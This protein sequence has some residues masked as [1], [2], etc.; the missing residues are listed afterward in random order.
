MDRVK[1]PAMNRI[2]AALVLASFAIVAC[3]KADTQYADPSGDSNSSGSTGGSTGSSSGTPANKAPAGIPQK[4][5]SMLDRD[6]PKIEALG[7][8]FETQFKKAQESRGRD[9]AAVDAASDSFRE[10][11]GLWGEIAYAA[12]DDNDDVMDAWSN[13]IRSYEKK[14]KGWTNKSK[15]LK[16]FSRVK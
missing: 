13:H 15:G 11:N 10:L 2:A 8:Q 14:V 1:I 12:Q 4:Y 16:E 6:W 7:A 3:G 5:Q 9:K